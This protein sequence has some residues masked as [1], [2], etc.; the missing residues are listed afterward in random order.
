MI[1][2]IGKP[3]WNPER[4]SSTMT[5]YADT[6]ADAIQALHDIQSGKIDKSKIPK[7]GLDIRIKNDKRENPL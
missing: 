7:T 5:I 6:T 4:F 1:V 2:T 3:D